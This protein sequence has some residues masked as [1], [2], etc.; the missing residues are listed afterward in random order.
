VRHATIR[1]MRQDDVETMSAAFKAIN[2]NGKTVELF[3]K[4]IDEH[5]RGVRRVL[6]A[7]VDG[8]FAGYLTIV[9]KTGYP[10]FR[11]AG[12]PEVVDFTVLPKLQSQR[13]GTQLMDAAERVVA[14]RSPLL[15]IGV[16]LN[17]Y[18]GVAQ[19]MYV[20]RGYVPDGRGVAY[21][22]NIVPPGA[23]VKNDDSLVLHFTKQLR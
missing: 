2:W 6:V 11:D 17:E 18:Y 5:T 3:R 8:A 14:E 1:E 20:R 9:W 16:C 10:L 7:E 15:G 4:Y 13:I 12:I 19:R 22:D 23:T 21:E